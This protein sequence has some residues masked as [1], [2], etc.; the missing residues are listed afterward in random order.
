MRRITLLLSA[1]FVSVVI[2]SSSALSDGRV[3]LV[4]GNGGYRSVPSLQNPP[5]D[6]ADVALSLGRLGFSVQRIL[7]ATYDD[8]RR[9]L[10]EFDRRARDAEM[11]IVFY[12]GHGMEVGGDNWLIPIDA[13]L[14]TDSDVEHE[15]IALKSVLS[16]V[17]GASKLGLVILDACRQQ[18][19]RSQDAAHHTHTRRDA[20]RSVSSR[21]G[22]CSLPMRRRMEPRQT[23]DTAATVRSRRPY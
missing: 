6:A 10:L 22:M 19:I 20:G 9:A 1:I 16:T 18:S 4:I 7:D 11:A 8:M 12:A 13:E 15:A 2:S 5:N 21:R 17:D 23:T 14:R 3:A